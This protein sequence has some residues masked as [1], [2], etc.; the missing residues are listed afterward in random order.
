MNA[1]VRNALLAG[2]ALVVATTMARAQG[3]D[4]IGDLLS[5][6][7]QAPPAPAAP[8]PP[9]QTVARPLS[10]SD[11]QLF[12]QGLSAARRGD[13][14]GARAIIQRLDDTVA[15]RTVTWALVDA[16]AGALSFA[17]LDAARRELA[18]FP[19]PGRRQIA[20]ERLVET[21]GKSPSE[22][23]AWFAGDPPQS[24]QGAMALA[25]AYRSLGRQ[26][27]A[28][29]LIRTWW[30][31]RSFEAEPQRQMLTRFSDVLTVDDHIRRADV[32][33]YGAQGPAARDM[34]TLLPADRQPAAIARI[35][36][37]S[38]GADVYAALSP[39][40]QASPGVAFERAAALRRAG[41]E[42][43]AI[44]LL[45]NF[46]TEI[47]T[48][49][50]AD[51]M[52]DERKRLVAY[53]LKLNNWRAAYQAAANSGLNEGTDATEAEFYAG[54]IALNRLNDAPAAARH[55]AAIER[56]G[57]SPI[58]RGRALYW[59]GRAAEQRGDRAGAERH[60]RDG[61]QYLTSFYGQLAA[62]KV[63]QPIRLASDPVPTAAERARFEGR[64]EV[65]AM[66]LLADQG[67]RDLFRAF[68]LHIDDIL[69][70]T[71]E[72]AMLVDAIRGYGDQDTSMKAIRAAA[73]RNL[74]LID[75]GYPYR[76]PPSVAGAPEPALVLGITRQESGFDPGVRSHADARGMMQLLPS[77]A[78][79]VARRMGEPYS[80]PAALYEA[81]YNMRLG[82]SF[83]GQ[84]VNQ[85]SGSYV[86]A[87]AGYNA[88]PGRPVQWINTCGDPRAG[89][90]DPLDFIEC[91][92]FSETRN[93]VM[94]VLENMTV[95]RAKLNGGSAPITLSSDLRRGGY[96]YAAATGAATSASNP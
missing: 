21:S 55:F 65:Q 86:M 74:I 94:R 64:Q 81:D 92:P 73:T 88:G 69:P 27:E 38:G 18:G 15:R 63:G 20:A 8:A 93:Y 49:E 87:A 54:W 52:W 72:V 46:P 77:T 3:V 70:T 71:V 7:A 32:L 76:T 90:N 19:R 14:A 13:V 11:Q 37:R 24:A 58:T 17:E 78:R 51:R 48:P 96:S 1:R 68:A 26:A 43:E 36:L 39:A 85:F 41:R 29:E 5:G 59:M 28:A 25:S 12:A 10:A 66:R 62:E 42:A 40:D 80:G 84:L 6:G 95:Y 44:A 79:I 60:Y 34:V 50:G 31:T 57:S 2:C 53:A 23:V 82:S 35:A 33:L 75:R 9:R 4:P 61:A 67:Q 83:L 47:V 56:I 45:P 91:I 22:I 16:N 30:R 89:S